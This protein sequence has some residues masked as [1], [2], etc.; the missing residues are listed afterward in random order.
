[1]EQKSL[2]DLFQENTEKESKRKILIIDGSSLIYRVYYALPPLK[3]KN[4]ELTNALY[5]FIRILLKAVEDFNPDLV[6]VAFD[7]PE[8]T[9]RHVIYKEYKA[10]RP[11]MKDDLKAQIPWIREFLRLNDIPL[12][13]EPGYE[14][15][16]II[17]T[18]V[19]KYKD[20]LKYIL[21]GDLDLLQLVSDKTFLI[22]PQKGITEFTIYDP[23]AVKDRFGVEP[24][25]IPL[26]KVLVGD[27]S[28]NIPGVN[29]IGPKKAS[30]I[31][32]KISSVDEFKSKIKV[33]D[34]DLRELIEKNWNIIERNL[35]LV[36]LKNI[37]K[38]LI[39]KPFEIKRDEKV[40]DFLKRYELKSILQKLFPDLQE[41]ENIEIKDVEEIN[42]NEV[43]KEGYF[44]FKCLGDRAF[45]GISLSFK[46]GEGYFISPFDF[47]NEIRKKIEN[48][49]SSENVKKIG[50]YIQ[51]DLHFLNCKIKGDVFDVSLASYLLNPERQNHSLDILIGEYLNKTSFIPQKYAGYLFP[52]KSILEERIKNEGLEFVLYNIEI[53]LI[54]VLYSME[55]WG[56]KVDKEYLKQLSDEFCERIKK[57]EEEIYELAGT[58][59]NLNSP[60]QLSEVLFERL[61]LPSGKK[62]KTGYSTS[63]SVLQ[64]LINAHP[65]VRKILQYREL[66]KLK[67]TYVDAIPNLVNPQTGRVHTKFNPTGT[68]TGRISSS[69]PNLQ[70][71]PIK[72]EEGRKIR[73]AFVSEDG[74]FLVS[75]DYSQIE[76]RIMAHLSQ[77]PKLISAFQKGEDIHRRTASE[78]F[79]VPEEEVDDLLRS[80][81]KAVNFGI[82]YG[83]SSFGLSETVSITPEEAEKFIDS[84]FKHYPRVKLFI[85]KTIHEAREKLYV[86]TLFGR[87]R[88]IP[89][90]KSIN[91][92]VRNAY[93]RIAINAPIQGTAADIIKLAMIEIYKEIEN[94]NLKSRILLQI[95]DELILEVPEEEMEFTPLMAKEKM[96]KVVELSVPLVVEISVGK[97]LAELK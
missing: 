85:D 55:K 12:L 36:T 24:Y 59:F 9:F 8:P 37:D 32:E 77:E 26:Y 7:R 35:E 34:S 65:I 90:I 82:I 68:A 30:K 91:K 60:K 63:S 19:N 66:Y 33:L 47:N 75:L 44:A 18:I 11:P 14:A 27:E 57:L 70:N 96:E 84:Y 38:D 1:M 79:G 45:E 78:I 3:T 72:S 23:K 80:R 10:K 31:L 76:L 69:E 6:G 62:G 71:I 13:E 94:K 17:A 52:L 87:K 39:L 41:E 25:K 92:Q 46:E 40:I 50:S 48:I 56:I 64:N 28:D 15:D 5:G 21:S 61:K 43:E 81:A 89:E 22:H 86:K 67:S 88:Y 83:I 54:P 4:G 20:D 2:W 58:R 95:H 51:R 97:N 93:E 29:G 74:Y 16:D 49:I 73:R 42:F 53:P